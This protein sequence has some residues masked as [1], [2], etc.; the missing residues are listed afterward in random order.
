MS[1]Y[2][3]PA[4]KSLSTETYGWEVTLLVPGHEKIKLRPGH[5]R[6]GHYREISAPTKAEVEKEAEGFLRV[7]DETPHPVELKDTSYEGMFKSVQLSE[8]IPEQKEFGKI[9]FK[10]RTEGTLR[11]REGSCLK[12]IGHSG[13]H[14]EWAM[15]PGTVEILDGAYKSAKTSEILHSMGVVTS[16]EDDISFARLST[17]FFDKFP[18]ARVAQRETTKQ[19]MSEFVSTVTAHELDYLFPELS[20]SMELKPPFSCD[21]CNEMMRIYQ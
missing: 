15:L 8:A 4:F 18:D 9:P 13:K 3:H 20:L 11:C 10:D 12:E 21:Y 17:D 6:D 14:T 2:D 7:Y 5:S 1:I 16:K 19:S